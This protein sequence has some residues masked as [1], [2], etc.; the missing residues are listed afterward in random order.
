MTAMGT[1][2]SI[3]RLA[4]VRRFDCATVYELKG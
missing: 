3:R 2:Q 4:S 1:A